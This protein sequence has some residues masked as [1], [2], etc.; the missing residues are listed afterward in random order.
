MCYNL[1]MMTPNENDSPTIATIA[2]GQR[3]LLHA[4]ETL[5]QGQ[6]NLRG[7]VKALT[8]GQDTLSEAVI[9]L[10]ARQDTL[11]GV[12][13]G[14]TAGQNKL[15]EDVKALTVGQDNLNGVVKGLTAGQNKLGEDVKALTARQDTLS[16][17]VKAL[18]AR[19][20]SLSGDVKA[21]TVG[22]NQLREFVKE[23][24]S[25]NSKFESFMVETSHKL[26]GLRD[27]I[28]MVKGGHAVSAMHHNSALIADELDCRLIEELPQGVILA[29]AKVAADN[30]EARSEVDSFRHADMVMHVENGKSQPGYIAIEASFTVDSDDVRRAARNAEYLRRYTGL[31]AYAVVAGVDVL[32]EA[33]ERI[34]KGHAYLWRIKPRHLQAE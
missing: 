20:D 26:N 34:K 15:S 21:L 19:Q 29:L 18:T 22:M 8:A 33:Q 13:K 25:L 31:S 28:A 2:A 3:H 12:V 17:D 1:F 30:G 14:L 24:K 23:Q 16:G 32:P 27:D 11:N 5:I 7:D 9:A 6:N 10:T 4:V